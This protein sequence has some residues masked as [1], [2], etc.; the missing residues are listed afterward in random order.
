M[1]IMCILLQDSK[2]NANYENLMPDKAKK[3]SDKEC[4][5]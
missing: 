2:Q 5:L 1:V 4:V 3:M